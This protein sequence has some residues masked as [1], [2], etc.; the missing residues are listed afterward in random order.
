MVAV[1]HIRAMHQGQA[2][3]VTVTHGQNT[4]PTSTYVSRSPGA[5]PKADRGLGAGMQML[6]NQHSGA[7]VGGVIFAF[8]AGPAIIIFGILLVTDYR[9]IGSY[10]A[11]ENLRFW[12]RVPNISMS[13]SSIR[14]IGIAAIL[15][16]IAIMTLAFYGLSQLR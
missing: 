16:G 10:L 13:D 8:I 6:A 4:G 15:F 12:S 3:S 7:S 2:W 14:I 9:G 1:C 5:I 11:D